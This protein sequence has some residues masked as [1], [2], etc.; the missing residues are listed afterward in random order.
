MNQKVIVASSVQGYSHI[1]NN[2][3]NQDS[4]YYVEDKQRDITV[5]IVSDG[6]GSAKN[7]KLG[8]SLCCANLAKSL[9]L[10][11][12]EMVEEL[13]INKEKSKVFKN[14]IVQCITQHIDLL[15]DLGDD[16]KSFNHTLSAIIYTPLGGQIIQIGDSPV[17]VIKKS[18]DLFSNQLEMDFDNIQVFDEKK[19]GEYANQTTFLT[20]SEWFNKLRWASLS[21]Q[22][23]QAILVMTDGT[24]SLLIGKNEQREK[25]L[26]LPT[27]TE[28]VR[29]FKNHEY[30]DVALTSLLSEKEANKITGDD[31]TLVIYF[32]QMWIDKTPKYS[33]QYQNNNVDIEAIKILENVS[34]REQVKIDISTISQVN[35]PI[36][37]LVQE[38]TETSMYQLEKDAHIKNHTEEMVSKEQSSLPSPEVFDNLIKETEQSTDNRQ[39]QEEV[40]LTTSV[41]TDKKKVK[42]LIALSDHQLICFYR[43][44]TFFCLMLLLRCVF[45]INFS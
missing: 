4:Y 5:I 26:S 39:K 45:L 36:Q 41:E 20:N 22:D 6:A 23:V 11:T 18:F 3:P 44:I 24:G 29:R 21:S 15:S 1:Q 43:A 2:I 10:I 13:K 16:I 32:P 33:P 27:F 25:N 38:N 37:A 30:L 12:Q 19:T 14:K 42:S 17:V 7:A 34:T 40:P 28:L 35:S 31:K 9:L 8:S